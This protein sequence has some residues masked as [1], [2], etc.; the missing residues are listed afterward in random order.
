MI[1]AS[2]TALTLGVLL[3]NV[4]QPV[5]GFSQ[6][7]DPIAAMALETQAFAEAAARPGYNQP[8]DVAISVRAGETLADAI[9]RA[10]V[11]PGEAKVAVGLL[12]KAFDVNAPRPGQSL[13]AAI[14]RPLDPSKPA[15]LLGL[16][17]RT[18]PAKQLALTTSGDGVMRL[19]A[20]EEPIRAERRVAIGEIN[21]SLFTSAA[22]MGATPS[23][24]QQ[25]VKLFAHKVDFQRDIKSGDTFKLV[26]DRKV[27][28]SGRTVEA[29][30]LLYAEIEA[31]GGIDRFYSFQAQGAKTVE[32][33]DEFGKNIKGFLLA[34]PISGARTSSGFG[35]RFHPIVGFMKM[36]TGIDFAAPTG[37]KIEAAGDGV[38]VDAKWWGGYGRWVRIRHTSGWETGYA[39]MSSIAV[40]PGQKV[41]QGQVIGYVGTTGRST[42]P[43]LHFEVWKDKRP[44]DP[45]S[46][47]VPQSNTLTGPDLIAFRARKREIDTMVAMADV[48]RT[49]G[50]GDSL[51]MQAGAYHFENEDATS[52]PAALAQTDPAP[53]RT[54]G[55]AQLRPALSST[56]GA[57]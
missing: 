55:R 44:I 3:W 32:Y 40:K 6:P 43:H 41:V 23:L 42:G 9:V 15:Q 34:T 39:H 46:A 10:G 29:G 27:T 13:E 24:T 2:A 8:E 1:F 12:S 47:K 52:R 31:K 48:K 35:M 7:L 57:R 5:T 25:V 51:A 4:L 37:T 18:G 26:F 50:S 38:V 30:N 14:A 33:Y 56:R 21:G 11:S 17:V 28:E 19:R 54:N 20:L 45:R 53:V 22:A 36:H 49:D 16:T